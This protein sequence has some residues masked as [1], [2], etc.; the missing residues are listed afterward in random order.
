MKGPAVAA[1]A[2]LRAHGR[3]PRRR[4]TQRRSNLTA[5]RLSHN[6]RQLRDRFTPVGPRGRPPQLRSGRGRGRHGLRTA[7][8]D[9]RRAPLR[10]RMSPAAS[11]RPPARLGAGPGTA[12]WAWNGGRDRTPSPPVLP[13]RPN[14]RIPRVR[15]GCAA[16]APARLAWLGGGW[17]GEG[18][19]RTGGG[20]TLRQRG[21][22]RGLPLQASLRECACVLL[23]LRRE[24][25]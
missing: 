3:P 9:A 10:P 20:V 19:G 11:S 6:P 22:G 25:S 21:R 18:R 15:S 24:G 7:A 5:V 17:M 14:P 12:A 4:T 8:A 2:P 16:T 1:A 13:E 23:R